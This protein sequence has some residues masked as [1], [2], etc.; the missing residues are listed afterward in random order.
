MLT[1]MFKNKNDLNHKFMQ[2]VCPLPNNHYT[3]RKKWILITKGKNNF[4]WDGNYMRQ[5]AAIMTDTPCLYEKFYLLPWKTSKWKSEIGILV[6]ISAV[7]A[8]PIFHNWVF[9]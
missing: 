4:I 9:L 5:R 2:E 8:N 3:L 6:I 1:E 7:C